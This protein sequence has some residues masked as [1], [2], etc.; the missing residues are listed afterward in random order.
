LLS[1]IGVKNDL[2]AGRFRMV[3]EKG[4]RISV[5]VRFIRALVPSTIVPNLQRLKQM[6]L[7]ERLQLLL[8]RSS[9]DLTVRI[10]FPPQLLLDTR[11]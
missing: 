1:D 9:G 5:P 11:N 3:G 2:K 8:Q 6:N 4:R 7:D 10:A